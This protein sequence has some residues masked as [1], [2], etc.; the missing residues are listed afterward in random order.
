VGT[1]STFIRHVLLPEQRANRG[2][3]FL[4]P[5]EYTYRGWIPRH[6]LT[7]P[8]LEG[9]TE[10]QVLELFNSLFSGSRLDLPHDEDVSHTK[11][12]HELKRIPIGA[13]RD[14][15]IKTA[16]HRFRERLLVGV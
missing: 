7:D 12:A 10:L 15:C 14:R 13:R 6:V 5:F 11:M 8:F 2:R 3:L 4:E 16:A 9:R 1:T